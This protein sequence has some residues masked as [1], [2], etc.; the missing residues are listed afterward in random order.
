MQTHQINSWL[1][2]S[3]LSA[4]TGCANNYPLLQQQ[5]ETDNTL[6][7]SGSHSISV[8]AL[9]QNASTGTVAKV[10]QKKVQTPFQ[11][12]FNDTEVE[13]NYVQQQRLQDYAQ[14]LS[15]AV[16]SVHCGAGN[17]SS[18]LQAVS[19][20]LRRCQK[21]QRFLSGIQQQS[22][23]LVQADTPSQLIT[24]AAANRQSGI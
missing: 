3:C 12:R 4:L 20:A 8:S 16:L 2:F 15:A 23:A 22:Q 24:V 5:I 10:P 9:L 14:S 21:I 13:L 11:L 7:R 19:I 17:S 1:L 18:T 6:Y